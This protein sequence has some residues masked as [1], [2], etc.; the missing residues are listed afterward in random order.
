MFGG[1]DDAG[2]GELLGDAA[3]VEDGLR[4]ERDTQF[5]AG[6]AVALLV[7]EIAVADYA[8][9]AARGVGLVELGEDLVD[10]A[11]DAWVLLGEGGIGCERDDG[12]EE[13]CGAA[14]R[15][16]GWALPRL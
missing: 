9:G 15:F 14:E 11:L 7:D 16:H 13:Y 8:Q 1:E 4:R 3:H 10:F 6:R 12:E 2:G 5:E